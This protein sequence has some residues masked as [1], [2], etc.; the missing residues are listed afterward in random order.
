MDRHQRPLVW[1]APEPPPQARERETEAKSRLPGNVE[2]GGGSGA[3][4]I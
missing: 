4:A 3:L 1:P 2:P